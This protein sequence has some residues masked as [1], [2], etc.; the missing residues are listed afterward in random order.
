LCEA[1]VRGRV[2]DVGRQQ[3]RNRQ[4]HHPALGRGDERSRPDHVFAP[5]VAARW[6]GE[7]LVE[8]TLPDER[9]HLGQIQP[10]R[11]VIAV[12][13]QNS[14]P[15][16]VVVLKLVV[17]GGELVDQREVEGV[18]L[19]GPVQADQQHVAAPLDGH[20]GLLRHR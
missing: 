13:E 9:A 16:R 3:E 14:A 12:A 4:G 10:S 18:A 7:R 20:R 2:A 8:T 15:D 17:G 1:R 19:L 5:R 6:P 11:E